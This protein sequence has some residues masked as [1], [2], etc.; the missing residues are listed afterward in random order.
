MPRILHCRPDRGR[1]T[2]G[3]LY[4]RVQPEDV[5]EIVEQTLIQGQIVQRLCYEEP[6]AFRSLASYQDMPLF[7]KQVRIAL[8]NCGFIDPEQIDDYIARDGYAAL[9]KVLARCRPKT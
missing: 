1:A 9:A 4:C 8:R 3:V 5:P 2:A 6:E 7:S